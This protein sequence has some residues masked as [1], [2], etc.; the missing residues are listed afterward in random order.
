MSGWTAI[1]YGAL[2]LTSCYCCY[3]IGQ[4]AAIER[5]RR[6]HDARRERE[7]RWSEFYD[8]DFD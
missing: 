8:E 7:Q 5:M 2:S 6:E 3:R 4:I 1:W